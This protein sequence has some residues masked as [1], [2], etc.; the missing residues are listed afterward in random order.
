MK[1]RAALKLGLLAL[2]VPGSTAAGW[3][4]GDATLSIQ[5]KGAGVGGGFK[6]RLV[7]YS[8]LQ[9]PFIL[10]SDLLTWML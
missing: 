7:S 5:T 10:R 3:G 2:V 4:F 6:E 1:L 9:T 8:R